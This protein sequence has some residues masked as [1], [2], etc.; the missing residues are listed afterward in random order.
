MPRDAPGARVSRWMP[1]ASVRSGGRERSSQVGGRNTPTRTS[2]A[3]VARSA[4]RS[5]APSPTPR[6]SRSS[7][8]S[9]TS[10]HASMERSSARTPVGVRDSA[11]SRSSLARTQARAA[12][13]PGATTVIETGRGRSVRPS[14]EDAARVPCAA[15]AE[16]TPRVP[17]SRSEGHGARGSS[18][19]RRGPRRR[20]AKGSPSSLLRRRSA[21]R[22]RSSAASDAGT[23]AIER[24]GT[25]V[26]LAAQVLDV[27]VHPCAGH[28]GVV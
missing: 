21:P 1:S 13:G 20:S 7:T 5:Q 19:F 11:R 27:T 23:V 3:C 12:S 22:R 10:S 9:E 15:S 24:H 6:V 4:S 26:Y 17:A 28:A 2:A 18:A 14:L 25:P 8:S 16:S